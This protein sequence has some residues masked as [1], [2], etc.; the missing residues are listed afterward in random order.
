[1]TTAPV[2]LP[3]DSVSRKDHADPFVGGGCERLS[4]GRSRAVPAR[5]SPFRH[6]IAAL[7]R[8]PRDWIRGKGIAR[9]RWRRTLFVEKHCPPGISPTTQSAVRRSTSAGRCPAPGFLGATLDWQPEPGRSRY[10]DQRAGCKVPRVSVTADARRQLEATRRP[11]P[12]REFDKVL[13]ESCERL[14]SFPFAKVHVDIEDDSGHATIFVLAGT[15]LHRLRASNQ[16]TLDPSPF[17]ATYSYSCDY[18]VEKV[19]ANG[20]FCCSIEYRVPEVPGPP[21]SPEQEARRQ[22]L[23]VRRE[24]WKFHIMSEDLVISYE[25]RG[26]AL[27]GPTFAKSL[28]TSFVRSP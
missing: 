27:T 14:L 19:P 4:P 6:V 3:F 7:T 22:L 12:L 15:H 1:V 24:E 25:T 11:G 5:A 17:G 26:K 2:I 13:L 21:L 8:T 9:R 23:V 16:S 20:P 18:R 10:C 28:A